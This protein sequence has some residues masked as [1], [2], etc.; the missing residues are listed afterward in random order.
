MR[1]MLAAAVVVYGLVAGSVSATIVTAHF[2]GIVT[3]GTAVGTFGY[4]IVA[5]GDLTG[6]EITGTVSYDTGLLGPNC[7]AGRFFFGCFVGTGTGGMTITE[8]IN[9]VTQLFP[10]TP[11]PINPQQFNTA[12]SGLLLDN[13]GVDTVNFHTMSMIGSPA[14]VYN[15][16]EAGIGVT[17]DNGSIADATNPVLSY[18]GGV[19]GPDSPYFIDKQNF[20]TNHS[21]LSE[22]T[23]D[24]SISTVYDFDIAS[25][26]MQG[27]VPEPASWA[28]LVEGFAITGAALR[29]RRAPHRPPGGRRS[30]SN[31]G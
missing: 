24:Y 2:A 15:G 18:H 27:S 28:L 9:G 19:I 16:T 12:E 5:P 10:G 21:E 20:P 4:S 8:T 17:L 23:P 30:C 3:S 31:G 13:F 11:S 1:K 29:R 14:T 26:S 25:F 7:P 22:L 6:K